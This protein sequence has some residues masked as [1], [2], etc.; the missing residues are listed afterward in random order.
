[1]SIIITGKKHGNFFEEYAV[2]VENIN[3]IKNEKS[4]YEIYLKR[5]LDVIL[6]ITCI[7]VL[8][9]LIVMVSI[10]IKLES[11][12]PI[13]YVQERVGSSGTYFK[14]YKLRSMRIDSEVGG[15]KLA[16]KND[17]RVTKVGRFIRKTRI[18][19]LPQ[20]LN[21]LLGHMSLIGPR[22]ERPIFTAKFNEDVPGFVERLTVKPG[23]TGWAQING[24]YDVT[25]NEKLE[26]DIYYVQNQS[27]KLDIKIAVKT[28]KVIVTGEGAR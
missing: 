27:L 17:S 5:F 23:L 8:F 28:V 22:P 2:A 26:L 25:P 18:D 24:G 13:F 9:P 12:G 11:H 14:M 1:M 3:V 10:L 6:S 7:F 16:E 20:L 19:E 4:F 15:P 21:V